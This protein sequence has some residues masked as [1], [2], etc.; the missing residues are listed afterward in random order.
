MRFGGGFD[1]FF[2]LMLSRLNPDFLIFKLLSEY[3]LRQTPFLPKGAG[4]CQDFFYR[5]MENFRV[6]FRQFRP[7]G[8][9]AVD[10]ADDTAH[11]RRAKFENDPSSPTI[12]DLC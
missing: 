8:F 1:L 4:K 9:E 6:E 12:F 7:Q 11:R 2:H 3:S 10:L 5:K